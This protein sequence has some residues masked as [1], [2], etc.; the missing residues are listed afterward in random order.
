MNLLKSPKT[1]RIRIVRRTYSNFWERCSR[2]W[3]NAVVEQPAAGN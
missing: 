1:V 3:P 2:C